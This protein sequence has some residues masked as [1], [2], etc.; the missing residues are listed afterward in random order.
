MKN[1][2]IVG[3]LAAVIIL[4]GCRSPISKV[5][6]G[7]LEYNKT[8]TVGQALE[9]SF[10]NGTW[11]SFTTEKGVTIVEFDGSHP[12][13][14]ARGIWGNPDSAECS[15]NLIC[16]ALAKKLEDDCNSNSDALN[17]KNTHDNLALQISEA[18]QQME[19]LYKQEFHN[20]NVRPNG[21]LN[22]GQSEQQRQDIIKQWT[23]NRNREVD[24]LSKKRDQLQEQLRNL[25]DP[26]R[27]CF[28]NAYKQH[29]GDPIPVAVQFSINSEVPSSTTQMTCLGARRNSF[30][31]CTSRRVL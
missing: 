3:I 4:T 29:A 8:T 21:T 7:Y 13:K 17:Y 20:D 24:E 26:K 19:D 25:T 11:K 1:V 16:A 28:D 12:F 14:E 18:S 30:I 31:T 15:D 2:T 27:A 9:H 10:Q 22:P 23:D 5:R 6:N